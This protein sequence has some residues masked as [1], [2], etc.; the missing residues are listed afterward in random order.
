MGY[1]EGFHHKKWLVSPADLEAMYAHFKGKKPILL[2]CGGRE[3]A[4]NSGDDEQPHKNMN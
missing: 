3:S 1:F 4:A 2:W